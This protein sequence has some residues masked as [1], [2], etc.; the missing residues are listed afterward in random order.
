MMRDNLIRTKLPKNFQLYFKNFDQEKR[1]NK[2]RDDE[3]FELSLREV[4]SNKD[5]VLLPL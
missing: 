3:E 5:R 2:L 4:L 1:R